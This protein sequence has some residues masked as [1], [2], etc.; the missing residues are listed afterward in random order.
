MKLKTT[1]R[2]EDEMPSRFGKLGLGER[3]LVDGEQGI[4]YGTEKSGAY[5]V[6]LKSGE[7]IHRMRSTIQRASR[8]Y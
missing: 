5:I 2:S 4:I 1:F 6:R 3:V 7:R 8:L